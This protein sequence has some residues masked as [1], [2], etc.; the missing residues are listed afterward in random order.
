MLN[1]LC[2][3]RIG[4]GWAYDV[5]T[6]AYHM[7][8]HSHAYVL[9]FHYILIYFCCLGLFWLFLSPFLSSVYVSLFLWHPNVNLLRPRTLLVPGHPLLL[10]LLLHTSG[11]VMRRLNRTFLRTFLDEAFILNAKSSCQTSPTLT[12]PLSF[13]VG[14]GNHC[15]MSRS[16]I[17]PCWSRSFTST[18]MDLIFQYISSLLAFEVRTLLSHRRL[19]SMCSVSPG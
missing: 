14:N 15:V 7:F 13:T 11:F 8:M 9:S 4:L 5:F 12:F 3:G 16:H 1:W 2:A 18:C 19:S 10:N 6:I 17:H